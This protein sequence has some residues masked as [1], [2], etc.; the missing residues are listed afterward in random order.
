MGWQNGL[1]ETG[2]SSR[3]LGI[4]RSGVSPGCGMLSG[5]LRDVPLEGGEDFVRSSRVLG[6][7]R[8]G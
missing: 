6:E 3:L 1:L 5:R 2:S 4:L 8:R 7:A